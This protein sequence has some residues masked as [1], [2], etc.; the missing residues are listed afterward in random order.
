VQ[1]S[2]PSVIY[3]T[4]ELNVSSELTSRR[5]NESALARIVIES[6]RRPIAMESQISNQECAV[7]YGQPKKTKNNI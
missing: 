5:R 6:S 4:S 7:Y 2:V 3:L 1:Q